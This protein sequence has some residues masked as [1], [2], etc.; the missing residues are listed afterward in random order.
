LQWHEVTSVTYNYLSLTLRGAGRQ[1]T[2]N[3]RLVGGAALVEE[4]FR[5]TA[6]GNK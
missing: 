6:P 3:P 1:I 4:I 2:L 5:R